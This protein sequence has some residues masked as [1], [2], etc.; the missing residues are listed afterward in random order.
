MKPGLLNRMLC[1]IALLVVGGTAY[2]QLDK[3]V[4]PTTEVR[5]ATDLLTEIRSQTGVR[6]SFDRTAMDS[7]QVS[8]AKGESTI[9]QLLESN[10]VTQGFLYRQVRQTIVIYPAPE[11]PVVQ[12]PTRTNFTWASRVLD[13][14]SGEPLPFAT[15][16]SRA[17]SATAD[18]RGHF[19]LTDI[20]SDTVTVIIM[21]VGYA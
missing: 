13:K 19:V 15:V 1:L 20:P 11:A 5:T 21:Y 7:L 16:T 10:L 3:K 4:V 2:G 18:A 9:Q 12:E 14:K 17:G 6:F 8:P